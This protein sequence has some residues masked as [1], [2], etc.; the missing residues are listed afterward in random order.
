MTSLLSPARRQFLSAMGVSS[1]ALLPS[2]ALPGFAQAAGL[3][4]Q[5]GNILV[6]VEL[7]G[8]NDGLNTV[9]PISDDR[10]HDLRPNI[11]LASANSLSL[12]ADTGLHPAMQPM[13]DLWE[14]GSLRIIEGVGYPKPD[15]SH[16]RS[17]EIWNTGGGADTLSQNGW[18]SDAFATDAPDALDAAG[19]VLG[20][21]MG[22]LGGQGRFSALREI[23]S[24]LDGLSALEAGPHAIRPETRA[25]TVGHVLETYESA[26]AT[27]E[28]IRAKLDQSRSRSWDFPDTHL[29]Q[30]LRNAARLMD[31]GVDAPVFKVVQDGY[32]TH[33]NQPDRHAKLLGDLSVALEAFS[34]S[35]KQI[36]IWDRVT[37]AT[38]SEFGRRARENGSAGTD[39]GTAAPLFVT[40]GAVKGGFDGERPL[41]DDL[42]DDDLA[43][44]TDYRSVYNAL[45]V[46][47]WALDR[48]PFVNFASDLRL[49]HKA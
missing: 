43:F 28:R 1:A 34:R 26:H 14:E 35:L 2:L 39:H 25:D 7:A 5:G 29:G 40:G 11:G 12:D 48:S 32:D 8:G 21:E 22:P 19:L 31:A 41:L 45:L 3:A 44:T 6:L 15:R 49:L 38:Y 17:I 33:D 16:F 42:V 23:D 10:Y 37:V 47:L 4:P 46:D 24:Y 27:G 30:Q 9:I 18:V 13:A 20:G 36:G